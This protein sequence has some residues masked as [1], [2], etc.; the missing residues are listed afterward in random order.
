MKKKF[1]Y[2]LTVLIASMFLAV[3]VMASDGG[4]QFKAN[5][6]LTAYSNYDDPDRGSE[7]VGG[8][9]DVVIKDGVVSFKYF[10][11]ELNIREELEYSPEGTVD[12]FIGELAEGATY[13]IKIDHVDIWG[14]IHIDKKM[15][16]LDDYSS[17]PPFPPWFDLDWIP[18]NA[19][20][21][22]IEDFVVRDIHI[23][24][25]PTYIIIE[26]GN[27]DKLGTTLVFLQ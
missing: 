5:G 20:V 12:Q 23:V 18:E 15:W 8:N 16:F 19:P 25:T 14:E 22:W 17:L 21:A 10:Y 13:Q 6:R 2:A 11:K 9:W 4:I 1:V 7:I 27:L 3:Q 24:I 26:N